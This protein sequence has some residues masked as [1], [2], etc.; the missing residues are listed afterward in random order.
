MHEKQSRLEQAHLIRDEIEYIRD[1]YGVRIAFHRPNRHELI[2]SISFEK[3]SI[4]EAGPAL[5]DMNKLLAIYPPGFFEKIGMS[6]IN[7]GKRIL[8]KQTVI[9]GL[10]SIEGSTYLSFDSFG[11]KPNTFHHEVFHHI[12]Y[13]LHYKPT[14]SFFRKTKSQLHEFTWK[15]RSWG[16]ENQFVEQ[17]GATDIR[18][19]KATIAA[20]MMTAPLILKDMASK[21]PA[22]RQK[23]NDVYRMYKKASGGLMDNSYF[24]D[25]AAGEVG[26]DYWEVKQ[27]SGNV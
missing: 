15:T 12:D 26:Q 21:N 6:E 1:K 11:I 4:E 5:R 7:I 18:E 17:Y 19:D 10:A 8:A 16:Y 20:M 23:T 25:L 27:S 3:I 14:G 13:N 2:H 24:R 22:I 9:E